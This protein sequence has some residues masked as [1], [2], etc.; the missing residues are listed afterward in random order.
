MA[1]IQNH[2]VATRSSFFI[3]HLIEIERFE[4]SIEKV[5]E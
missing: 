5:E 1:F 4:L 2:G 3:G